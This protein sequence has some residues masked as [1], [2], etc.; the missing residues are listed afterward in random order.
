[1]S[2]RK[3]NFGQVIDYLLEN[4]KEGDLVMTLGCGDAYKIAKKFAKRLR[5]R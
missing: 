5:E 1:M 3:K 2:R 4:T